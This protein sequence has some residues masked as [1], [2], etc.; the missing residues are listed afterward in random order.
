MAM[1]TLNLPAIDRAAQIQSSNAMNVEQSQRQFAEQDRIA[2]TQWLLSVAQNGMNMLEQNPEQL[3]AYV[4][5]MDQD[6]QRRGIWEKLGIDYESMDDQQLF[7]AAGEGF[8][9]MGQQAG[10]GLSGLEKPERYEDVMQDGRLTGQRNVATNQYT[11]VGASPRGPTANSADFEQLLAIEQKYGKNSD[12]Y[13]MFSAQLV[14]PNYGDI[15]GVRS[16]ST[17]ISTETLS[18]LNAESDAAAQIAL[19][20]GEGGRGRL[21]QPGGGFAAVPGTEA[22]IKQIEANRKRS[23]GAFMKSIQSQTVVDDVARLNEQINAGKVPFG[24]VAAIQEGLTP[25]LQTD[26]YRNANSLIE[27]VKGNVGIDSLLRIKATGAGLGQVP[28]SQL[29]LLSRLLGELDM[30]QSQEQFVYT[31][32]RMGQVYEI[33]MK[34]ADD[35]LYDLDVDRPDVTPGKGKTDAEIQQHL[36]LARDAIAIGRNREEIEAMLRVN[37]IDPLLLDQ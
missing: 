32:N 11:Q 19:A 25:A 5:M 7:Q 14:T 15:A 9:N 23:G 28:Q 33:I 36:Q 16:R 8:E 13:K 17:P 30:N 22:D 2:N 6:G 37:G 10:I 12:E 21:Q 20:T 35:E 29:D 31:W 24:R 27:S 26:G 34:Q 4:Q 3:R 1:N 18:T